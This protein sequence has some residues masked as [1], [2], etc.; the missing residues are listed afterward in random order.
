MEIETGPLTLLME[1]EKK[2]KKTKRKTEGGE[3]QMTIGLLTS[4][5]PDASRAWL[6]RSVKP[7]YG[8]PKLAC[9]RGS[10]ALVMPDASVQWAAWMDNTID[11]RKSETVFVQVGSESCDGSIGHIRR[12]VCSPPRPPG[13]ERIQRSSYAPDRE[14]LW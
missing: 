10:R 6:G 3:Q 1:H 14:R 9:E 13:T 5:S 2:K 4:E 11:V 12:K 8:R 7:P